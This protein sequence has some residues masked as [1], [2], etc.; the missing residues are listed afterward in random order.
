MR[1]QLGHLLDG[2]YATILVLY[3]TAMAK[4]Q[5]NQPTLG[6][7]QL[8]THWKNSSSRPTVEAVSTFNQ[9]LNQ[10]HGVLQEQG[11]D[12]DTAIHLAIDPVASTE[13]TVIGEYEGYV[14]LMRTDDE[15]FGKRVFC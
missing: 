4:F 12:L 5:F 15:E 2:L 1:N 14:S 11:L 9:L 8:S 3:F 7:L 6:K 13:S 10:H